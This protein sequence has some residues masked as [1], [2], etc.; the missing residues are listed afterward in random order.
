MTIL[1]KMF[2]AFRCSLPEGMHNGDAF[3][4]CRHTFQNI[5]N[6]YEFWFQHTQK[7]ATELNLRGWCRNTDTGTVLGCLEGERLQIDMM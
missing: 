6:A 7:K 4:S 2:Y 3:F 5:Y 1:Y